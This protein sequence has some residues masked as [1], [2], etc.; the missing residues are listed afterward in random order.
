MIDPALQAEIDAM[1]F[2]ERMELVAY[3]ER[4]IESESVEISE[5][6]KTVVRSRAAELEADPS[7]GLTWDKLSARLASRWG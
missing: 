4:T 2:D 6:K 3:I 1:S 7:I 5:E